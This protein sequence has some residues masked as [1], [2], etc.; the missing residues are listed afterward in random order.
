M[1]MI[2]V[3]LNIKTVLTSYSTDVAYLSTDV[4][5]SDW[6][7]SFIS[8]SGAIFFLMSYFQNT[9]TSPGN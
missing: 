4:C 7:Q 8:R 9:T 3:C 1:P 5:L 2:F 6:L